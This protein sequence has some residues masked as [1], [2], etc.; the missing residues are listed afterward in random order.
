MTHNPLQVRAQCT[1]IA[2]VRAAR[3]ASDGLGVACRVLE[4]DGDAHTG[5]E[6][7]DRDNNPSR[8]M[9]EAEGFQRILRS[10]RYSSMGNSGGCGWDL[11]ND[12]TR[13]ARALP[14]LFPNS[15]V[16]SMRGPIGRAVEWR[17]MRARCS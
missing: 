15:A 11:S 7:A 6:E 14:R 17:K 1:R 2:E 5:G 3:K 9:R 4:E 12:I 10:T 16:R 13:A 8:G